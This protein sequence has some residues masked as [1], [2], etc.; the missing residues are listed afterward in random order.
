MR[1]L[2]QANNLTQFHSIYSLCY[3]QTRPVY[4]FHNKLLFSFLLRF[5]LCLIKPK[6]T[7][8]Y[9]HDQQA[10]RSIFLTYLRYIPQVHSNITHDHENHI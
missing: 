8:K 10:G 6:Y 2:I 5:L 9:S 7:L 4:I 1:H 3:V